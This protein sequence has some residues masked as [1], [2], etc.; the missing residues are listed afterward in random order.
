MSSHATDSWLSSSCNER[1]PSDRNYCCTVGIPDVSRAMDNVKDAADKAASVVDKG[2]SEAVQLATHTA[3]D[4]LARGS[5]VWDTAKVRRC[6]L[7]SVCCQTMQVCLC[8]GSGDSSS[9]QLLLK[10]PV[11]QLVC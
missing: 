9:C 1:R 8:K 5:E 6:C 4:L 7:W 11:L 2:V 10:P 3:Q